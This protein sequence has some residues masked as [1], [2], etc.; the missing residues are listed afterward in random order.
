MTT[1]AV[2]QRINA[3]LNTV[4]KA[5]AIATLLLHYGTAATRA[6]EKLTHELRTR[7]N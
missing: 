1:T 6:T 3:T 5:V 2:T 4:D 7:I